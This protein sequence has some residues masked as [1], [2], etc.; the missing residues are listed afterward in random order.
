MWASRSSISCRN[1]SAPPPS[2]GREL[3]LESLK[4]RLFDL[5]V[6]LGLADVLALLGVIDVALG[7][8]RD[9]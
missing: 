6:D 7:Q 1:F 2:G 5:F 8:L 4:A 3:V 9:L